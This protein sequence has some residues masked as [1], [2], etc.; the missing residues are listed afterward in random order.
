MNRILK[1]TRN[2]ILTMIMVAGMSL[3]YLS[4]ANAA[5]FNRAYYNRKSH[6]ITSAT[7]AGTNYQM[8]I[9]VYKGAGADSLGNVYLGGKCRDDF[10]DIRFTDNDEVTALDYWMEEYTSGT[11]ATFW[12]EVAD[13]LGSNAT[14]YIYYNSG[15]GVTTSNG[16]NTFLFFDDFSGDLSKW[17]R[18]KISGVYP[19]IQAGGFVRLGGGS[20]TSPYGHTSLGSSATYTGFNNNA[21][22]GKVYLA[23]NS[24]GEQAFRGN[25]AGNTGYKSRI[26]ARSGEGQSILKPPYTS[27]GFLA[28]CG[29]DAVVP[30]VLTWYKFSITANGTALNYYRDG[31]LRRSCTDASYS[32]AGEVSLQNHYGSYTDYDD[33]RVRK[34]VSPEPVHSTW[35]TEETLHPLR[36]AIINVN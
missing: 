11:S 3:S 34:F 13:D 21:F 2:V 30:T 22:D 31:V 24:I 36:G 25:F 15:A 28:S 29:G 33:A 17:T 19:Q 7:G 10:G 1:T 20:T 8:K 32:T 26:D 23:A 14:I 9:V 6:L 4:D 12:V 5:W 16:T 18:E 27:W 35:G